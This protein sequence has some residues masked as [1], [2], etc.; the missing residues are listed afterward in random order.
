MSKR[1]EELGRRLKK[2]RL[3]AYIVSDRVNLEYLLG[4]E[5]DVGTLLVTPRRWKLFLPPMYREAKCGTVSLKPLR[6]FFRKGCRIGFSK[7][8]VGCDLL[9]RWKKEG[10]MLGGFQWRGSELVETMRQ[11]KTKGEIE[12]IEKAC[13]ITYACY[14]SLKGSLKEGITEKELVH[15]FECELFKR[16]AER[17]SFDPIMAFGSGGSQPHY[18]PKQRILKNGESILMDMGVVFEGYCSDMT[19]VTALGEMP[20]AVAEGYRILKEAYREA[21]GAC[22]V[23]VDVKQLD[24]IARDVIK[25]YGYGEDF[26][27]SLGHGL[28]REVHEGPRL[29]PYAKAGEVLEEGMVF[30]I[31]PGIYLS[32]KWGVRYEN[33]LVME[34]KGARS[35]FPED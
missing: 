2:A 21:L 34:K 20:S 25:H 17:V 30:T 16:G 4:E 6:D 14:Q 3:D 22:Q 1:I 35:L 29:S 10:R 19:R 15:Q 5:L 33:T 31:E 23:G 18:R 12:K 8:K 28:G 27:H 9:E 11:I 32:G 26:I 7:G 13:E 24:M